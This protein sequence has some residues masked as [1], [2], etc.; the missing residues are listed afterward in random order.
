METIITKAA[1]FVVMLVALF[2]L[3]RIAYPKQPK[4]KSSGDLRE[5]DTKPDHSVMGKSRFVL[6]DRSKPL[7]TP[8]ISTEFE[9]TAENA[10]IFAAGNEKRKSVIPNENLDEVF[11]D[12]SEDVNPE[13]LDLDADEDDG[14]DETVDAEEEA[15]EFRQKLGRDAE[16]ASGFSIEE[17]SEAAKAIDK[18]TDEKAK[19][20]FRVEKTDM[21][22]RMVSGD[23][24]KETL[25]K[26]IIDRYVQK[27]LPELES[28]I[29]DVETDYGNFDVAGFLGS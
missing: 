19:I 5:K 24:G 18:P 1:A 20:L 3:Y 7:Q 16:L 6:P 10:Y 13:D 23:E 26:A 9:K 2:L 8:A 14:Y 22:E 4:T 25:I 27:L 17:M 28:E 21:F 15:E 11:G 29:S 12:E